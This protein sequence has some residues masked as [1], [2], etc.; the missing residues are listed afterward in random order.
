MLVAQ[1][2]QSSPSGTARAQRLAWRVA[3]VRDLLQLELHAP[4]QQSRNGRLEANTM[5][6]TWARRGARRLT[7][8]QSPYRH[9]LVSSPSSLPQEYEPPLSPAQLTPNIIFASPPN[10]SGMH[11]WHAQQGL[12]VGMWG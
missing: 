8:F 11:T 10:L 3:S 5:G 1:R 2:L 4:V 7:F 6:Q 12:T 9:V